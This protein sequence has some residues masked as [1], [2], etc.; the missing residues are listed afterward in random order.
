MALGLTQITNTS[1]LSG[2]SVAADQAIDWGTAIDAAATEWFNVVNIQC[3]VAFHASATKDVEI[4]ARKSVDDGTT[5]DTDGVG[6]YLCTVPITAGA[7]VVKT[8]SVYD[9]NYLEVGAKNLDT[10]QVATVTIDYS[11]YKITGMA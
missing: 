4:H 3:A 5:D 9:F 8:I 1:I 6:T 10:G 7:T 11:G 2:Q